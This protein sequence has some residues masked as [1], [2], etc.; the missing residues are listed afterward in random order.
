MPPTPRRISRTRSARGVP[1]FEPRTAGQVKRRSACRRGRLLGALLG[2]MFPRRFVLATP[3][4]VLGCRPGDGP[5]NP[6]RFRRTI[7][8][9]SG[10]DSQPQTGVPEGKVT[11]YEW[12]NSRVYPG[13]VRN[14]GSMCRRN[15]NAA[16][17][18]ALMVFQDGGGYVKKD[19]TWRVHG[20]LRQSHREERNAGDGR[21]LHQSGR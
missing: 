1:G 9:N 10:P 7:N 12:N 13:T 19:G 3:R 5:G 2:G 18:A 6:N 17:P 20:G 21:C 8:T 4:H 14:T 16:K 11:E 15:T